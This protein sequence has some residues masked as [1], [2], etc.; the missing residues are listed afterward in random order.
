MEYT[1]FNPANDPK[2]IARNL[3][4]QTNLTQAQIGDMVGVTQ[5]TISLWMNDGKWKQLRDTVARAPVAL[6]EHMFSE[7]SELHNTIAAREP[8]MRFPT[9]KEAETRR[10]ISAAIRD[11]Q[12]Q[13]AVPVHTETM[14]N[15]IHYIKRIKDPNLIT[16][17][18]L[19]DT[20]LKGELKLGND[21]FRPYKLPEMRSDA[22][23]DEGGIP[24]AA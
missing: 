8:G 11:L 6:L 12:E 10:K 18:K 24:V 3:Y 1:D 2:E 13:D 21:A 4:F 19:A 5:K 9:L 20:Y 16:I 22:T 15:F 17:T 23:D 14:M 7:I